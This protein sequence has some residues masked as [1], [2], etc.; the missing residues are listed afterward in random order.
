MEKEMRSLFDRL[1]RL[2]G[3]EVE[4]GFRP[5]T[6]VQTENGTMVVT[7]EV[8]GVDPEKD[9]EITL[10]GDM[11][12]IKGEKT[13]EKEVDEKHRY[14]KERHYGSFLR[15]IPLPD[16]TSPDAVKA[17]YDKGVLKVEVPMPETP[18]EQPRSIPVKVG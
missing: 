14:L 17:T 10:E 3:E 15:R 2:F 4:M 9:I 16:G 8:P 13:I 6:D 7:V 1:P 11:L 5:T 12:T 18:I